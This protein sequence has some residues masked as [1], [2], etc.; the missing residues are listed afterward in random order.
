VAIR[1][2]QSKATGKIG[3]PHQK[4]KHKKHSTICDGQHYMQTN[5]NNVN[6]T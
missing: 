2:G 4:K 5:K 6:K 1:N 3:P